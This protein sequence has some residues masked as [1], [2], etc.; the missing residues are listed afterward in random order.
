MSL[1]ATLRRHARAPHALDPA[2]LLGLVDFM[3]GACPPGWLL[4]IPA[5]RFDCGKQL[6]QAAAARLNDA[7]TWARTWL[8]EEGEP[9]FSVAEAWQE[10]GAGD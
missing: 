2:A 9:D 5:S 8:L 7:L 1:R 3:H 10:V 6:T 4:S